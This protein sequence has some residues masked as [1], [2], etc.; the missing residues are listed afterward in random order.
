VRVI[1]GG[2]ESGDLPAYLDRNS[3]IDARLVAGATFQFE[4]PGQ[5]TIPT[6]YEATQLVEICDKY[7]EAKNQGLLKS[8]QKR[9]AIQAEIVIRACAKVGI[10]ALIDKARFSRRCQLRGLSRVPAADLATSSAVAKP[11]YRT[12]A[13]NMMWIRP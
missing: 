6:G 5:P 12:G 4:I 3:L 2:R 8:N 1:G 7:V 13:E 11:E 10:I 9:R